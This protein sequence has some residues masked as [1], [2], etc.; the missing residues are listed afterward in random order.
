ML[1]IDG[2][3]VAGELGTY[4]VCNPVRPVEVVTDA[5]AASPAQVDAAVQAAA[6]A[7]PAWAA[8]SLED[9]SA[10]LAA[11][12]AEV[13]VAA[14]DQGLAELLTRENG[15][16]LAESQLD[17]AGVAAIVATFGELAG[18][19]LAPRP[20]PGG[21]ELT[22][23]PAGVVGALLPFNWPVS[24]LATKVAPALLAG[25]TMV[26][27]PPPTCPTAVLRSAA[28][29][30]QALPPGVL[31]TVN[32]P[33]AEVGQLLAAHRQVGMLS[34]TGGIA[35]GRAVM[36]AAADRVAPVLLELGGN[37]AAIIAPDV[38]ITDEIAGRLLD[39][40]FVTSGQ[41]CIAL[42]R[43]YVP[44]R[45]LDE[46]VGALLSS[47]AQSVVGDG[48]D[49]ETTLGP[50]HTARARTRAE[51]LLA[52]AADRGAVVHWTGRVRPEDAGA[53]G[54]LVAPAIV[55]DPPPDT[56]IVA[57]E[58]FAPIVPIIGYGNLD[59]A[60]AQANAVAHGLG[61]SVWSH[62]DDLA[63]GL[64]RRLQA[65]VV[66]RNGHGPLSLDPTVPFGGWKQSGFG[67]EYGVEGVLSYTRSRAVLAGPA[68]PGGTQRAR[69][70]EE[71]A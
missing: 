17:V 60:V 41:V 26:V 3:D 47:G 62:D 30:A 67:R 52:E 1:T 39:A 51:E 37:D 68:L 44:V 49:P 10:R 58:Q 11:A 36:A 63:A 40:A 27:K 34:L 50:L 15:K 59:E 14:A 65:G 31:N 29:M 4:P 12:A 23:E 5:P 45:R 18:P 20:T 54:H 48:L 64:A 38:E 43:L 19:A 9:R 32:G 33:G 56:A 21:G 71:D 69:D 53:G 46:V 25:N 6:A 22:R 61:A 2:L 42:K 7:A 57:E 28:A 70:H 16:I 8:L 13:E 24:V 55:A 66:F 35:A